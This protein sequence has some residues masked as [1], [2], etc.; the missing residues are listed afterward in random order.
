M[1]DV[2]WTKTWKTTISA[3]GEGLWTWAVD[4]VK[5]PALLLIEA[6]GTWAY[7]PGRECGPDGDFRA[8][9]RPNEALLPAA[10]IGA[11]VMKVGGSTAG[12]SDGIVKVAG[13]KAI[14]EIGKVHGPVF[15]AIN[16]EPSGMDD[17]DGELT[18][19]VS[20]CQLKEPPASGDQPASGAKPDEAASSN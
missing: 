13:R 18:V 10:P 11:L 5:G 16:D 6:D 15:F 19:N 7:A 9:V 1:S 3:R 8:L 17:N 4:Y 2:T 20:Y 12:T 14:V